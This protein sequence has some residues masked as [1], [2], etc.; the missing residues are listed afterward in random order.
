MFIFLLIFFAICT[1]GLS[2]EIFLHPSFSSSR[3]CCRLVCLGT[4]LN[5][6]AF[7]LSKSA[8]DIENHLAGCRSGI[9]AAVMNRAEAHSPF[10]QL[11]NN[12]P[13]NPGPSC[14]DFFCFV[15]LPF[16]CFTAL[17]GVLAFS[18]SAR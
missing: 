11:F 13:N 14:G 9:N 12:Y 8:E 18:F 10:L 7:K 3:P 15:P 2:V 5:Q 6:A 4:F 1:F 16:P 17:T